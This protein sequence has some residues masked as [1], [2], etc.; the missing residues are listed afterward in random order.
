MLGE[1]LVISPELLLHRTIFFVLFF[2]TVYGFASYIL[3]HTRR[4]FLLS[5]G[6]TLYLFLRLLG[7]THWIYLVLLVAILVFV[8]LYARKR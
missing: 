7:L 1:V 8:E 2:F 6:L 3:D 5:A 4:A